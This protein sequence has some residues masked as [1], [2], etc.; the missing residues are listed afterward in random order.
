MKAL[1]EQ[2]FFPF[3]IRP[4]RYSGGEPGQIVKDPEGRVKYLHAF[5]DKYELGQSYLG[6]QTLYHVI[7]SDDRFLCERVF[8]V[9]NDAEQVMRREQIPLF[10]LESYRPANQ[11]DV[12]G[13]TLT[14]EL[15][16]TNVL[17]MLDLAGIPLRNRNRTDEGPIIMAGGPAVYN[18]E[19]L[20]EFIDLFFIG[21]AEEGLV[22]MLAVLHG[23]PGA[24]RREKLEAICREVSSVYVPSFYDAS[25][26]PLHDFAPDKIVA[27]LVTELKPEYY[28]KQPLVP[29]V[30]V[31]HS[32]L[33]VEIMRGCPQGCRFCQAGPIYRP[34]RPR[35]QKDIIEQTETQ[36][37]NTGYEE[38]SLVSLSSSDYPGID[39][40]GTSLARKLEQQKVSISLPSLRPGTLSPQL[41]EAVKQVRKAGLTIS[42]EAGTERLRLF[43]RKEIPD[44]AI[45]ETAALAFKL[46]WTTLKLYFMIGL[47]TETEDDL[48]GIVKLIKKIYDIAFEYPG[49]KTVNVTLSPFV[50]KAHTPFQWDELISADEMLRRINL[51]KRVNRVSQV[52]FKY[53][54][55][56][57]SVLQGVLGR[58][59]REMNEVIEKAYEKGCRFDGWSEDFKFERWLTSFEKC[60]IDIK[61][62]SRPIPFDRDLPWSHIQK[63]VSVEHLLKERQKTSLEQVTYE[64]RQ[65]LDEQPM[66]LSDSGPQFGRSKKRVI[67]QS[68]SAPTKNRLRIRWGK[69][70][71]LK[72]MSHLDNMRLIERSIRR[73]CLPVAYSQGH[74]PTMKLSFGPP[75]PLGFTSEAELLDITLETNL[76]PYMIEKL[77]SVI[78]DG[79]FFVEAKAALGKTQSLSAA[80]NRA[81]YQLNSNDLLKED[82]ILRNID[83]TMNAKELPVER[84]GKNQTT[85]VD[86]RPAI[87]SLTYQKGLLTMTL[88]IGEGGYARPSE[89]LLLLTDGDRQKAEYFAQKLHRFDLF[90]VEQNGEQISAMDV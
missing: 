83:R 58:G 24:S 48:I 60:G 30:D 57:T 10:S 37:K 4:G 78:P 8:A 90:R 42:P 33:A 64:S 77:K 79:L 71:R 53:P 12:V 5:P 54:M 50:P 20:A 26:K 39:E 9:D 40:L 68:T 74:N 69:T 65:I 15:V 44:A 16:Y 56:E 55:V 73:A 41:L 67:T 81:V 29:L 2:K 87:Y 22:E 38:I 25:R 47:P 35:P 6:L 34:V 31:V 75:L 1:L 32:H 59:G 89:I 82:V 36:L 66:R 17:A 62:H 49:R 88:G 18:P 27:R 72:Y 21:D 45:V 14:Y 19:P 63:S 76:M 43:I 23:M 61:E 86:I 7:N 3:V 70:D 11:F 28:P 85:V 13:F 46:G 52:N 84:A 80:L 51:I